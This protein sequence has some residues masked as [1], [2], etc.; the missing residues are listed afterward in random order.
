VWQTDRQT[1]RPHYSVGVTDVRI[2]V[3]LQNAFIKS[4]LSLGFAS[5]DCKPTAPVWN[6][7]THP[8]DFVTSA[9]GYRV[10][11][12]SHYAQIRACCNTPHAQ[13]ELIGNTDDVHTDTS[14]HRTACERPF[15][16]YR[17]TPWQLHSI[18]RDAVAIDRWLVCGLI[19]IYYLSHDSCSRIFTAH[20][21]SSRQ[22]VVAAGSL[23]VV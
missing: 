20:T 8:V 12:R 4:Q 16:R 3:R 1:D 23:P 5:L 13:I 10:K 19:L 11:S 2:Q 14:P 7:L 22:R 6:H 15:T 17:V 18:D 21:S 9:Q